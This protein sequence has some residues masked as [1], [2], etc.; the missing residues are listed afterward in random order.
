MLARQSPWQLSE[1]FDDDSTIS[2]NLITL[3][4]QNNSVSH[5]M[6]PPGGPLETLSATFEPLMAFGVATK[7][8]GASATAVSANPTEL[9]CYGVYAA[10]ADGLSTVVVDY[11]VE[12][13]YTVKFSELQT[14][15]QN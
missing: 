1:H 15:V 6:A 7:D 11:K 3:M 13:E 14:P 8:D 2:S 5:G 9:W 10:S 4:E 12:I